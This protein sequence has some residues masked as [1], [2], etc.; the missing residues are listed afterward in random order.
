MPSRSVWRLVRRRRLPD[1]IGEKDKETA[2]K[3][4]A[5]VL[6]LSL[7]VS[8]VMSFIGV[9]FAPQLLAILGGEPQVI[10]Q[11]TPFMRIYARRKCG[12]RIYIFAERD[13]S[14]RGRCGGGDAPFCGWRTV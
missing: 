11:G 1:G 13:L 5:H 10:V 12:R 14:R 2:A 7:I 8:V 4:A 6:Y 3:T 9:I